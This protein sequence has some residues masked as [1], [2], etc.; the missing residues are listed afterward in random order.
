LGHE[1]V[2]QID[3]VL[4]RGAGGLKFLKDLGLGVRTSDGRL[5]NERDRE[6]SREEIYHSNA[7]RIF[8]QFPG[9]PYR[10][11]PEVMKISDQWTSTPKRFRPAPALA[12]VASVVV[13]LRNGRFGRL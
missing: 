7:V 1:M 9:A 5:R 8:R 3:D 11:G 6:A 10:N 4:R 2:A 13:R 12:L